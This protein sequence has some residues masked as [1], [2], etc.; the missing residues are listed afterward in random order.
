MKDEFDFT[1]NG[2]KK[3]IVPK[4]EDDISYKLS[5]IKIEN[6]EPSRFDVMFLINMDDIL[7]FKIRINQNHYD[8]PKEIP[9][10]N[11]MLMLNRK[12]NL[13]IEAIPKNAKFTGTIKLRYCE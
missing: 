13:S 11:S 6:V 12:E 5:Y 1:Y 7:L 9:L 10:T 3:I 4:C 8:I 2:R